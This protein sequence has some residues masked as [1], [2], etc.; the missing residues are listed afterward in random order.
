MGC[1]SILFRI[2]FVEQKLLS[3]IRFHLL[4]FAF[5]SLRRNRYNLYQRTFCLYSMNFMVSCLIFTSLKHFELIFVS[6]VKVCS[7][8]NDLHV[9]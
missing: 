5:Y 9:L 1:L 7:N 8:F 6:G 2:S 4:I 3:L